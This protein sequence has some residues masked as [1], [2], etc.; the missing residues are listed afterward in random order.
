MHDQKQGGVSVVIPTY[1]HSA[2]IGRCID[3]VLGQTVAAEE[4]I[5]VDDGSTDD[6]PRVLAEFGD[7]IRYVRQSN[8][9]C[10]VARNTGISIA[11]GEWIALLDSDDVWHPRKLE[12]QLR[13]ARA[14][15]EIGVVY[16]AMRLGLDP[17]V[18]R[19]SASRQVARPELLD[20]LL[21]SNCITGSASC[22]LVRRRCFDD[23]GSFDRELRWA[24]DWDMWIRLAAKYEFGY[25]PEVLVS[26]GS[27]GNDMSFDVL[28][29]LQ[30]RAKLLEKHRALY[31]ATPGGRRLW[32]KVHSRT[33]VIEA[34]IHER[35]GNRGAARKAYLKAFGWWPFWSDVP[36]KFAR[37]LIP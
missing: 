18:A 23:V 24:E 35:S 21:F 5:V 1:N 9:G 33:H 11:R 37:S 10:G 28:S 29:M 16:G 25:V 14:N 30:G 27:S 36:K 15:P 3:S 7:R 34:Q 26:L 8:A 4:I 32:R 6:T 31:W 20:A 2:F 13:L 17:A 22:V 12:L 19:V